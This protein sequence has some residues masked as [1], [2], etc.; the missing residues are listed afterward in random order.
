MLPVITIDREYGSGG[1]SI[2]Q[3]VAERL[4]IP[5]YDG[6]ILDE[7]AEQSG[8]ARE[9]IAEEGE[10]A[11][12]S[13][14]WSGIFASLGGFYQEDPRDEIFRL[15]C[16]IIRKLAAEGPCVIVGRC[17]DYIL[18]DQCE[19]LDVFIHA[20]HVFR[21]ARVR[22]VYGEN[23]EDIKQYLKQRDRSRSTYYKYYTEHEWGGFKNYNL[24]LD[25]SYLGIDQCVD[26]IVNAVQNR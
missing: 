6:A 26:I 18:R 4:G 17:A 24:N 25:S 10:Y 22:E 23:P 9:T 11:P 7:V 20:N 21:F 13:K 2:G 15:Q 5:F 16:D 8:F 3:L 1:H 19:T 14:M 12:N